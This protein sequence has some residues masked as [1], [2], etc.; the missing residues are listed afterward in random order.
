MHV[1]EGCTHN[2]HHLFGK[3]VLNWGRLCPVS[4]SPVKV[5]SWCL[6]TLKKV[7][8]WCEDNLPMF[9]SNIQSKINWGGDVGVLGDFRISEAPEIFWG[10]ALGRFPLRLSPCFYSL[11]QR[12]FFSL[13][14]CHSIVRK[15]ELLHTCLKFLLIHI[16]TWV[17]IILFALHALLSAPWPKVKFASSGFWPSCTVDFDRILA[18]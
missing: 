11:T 5:K 8:L 18:R 10:T 3:S 6:I 7:D 16:P 12:W 4:A 9:R 2:S 17:A 15:P 14:L 13:L 1:G